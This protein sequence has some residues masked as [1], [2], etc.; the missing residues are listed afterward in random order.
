MI[1]EEL[2]EKIR[3]NQVNLGIIGLG[4]VG[5]PLA[6]HFKE[7]GC[8]VHGFDIDEEKINKLN[9][10]TSY[11]NHIEDKDIDKLIQDGNFSTSDFS[12]ISDMDIL[13]V[14]VPTPIDEQRNPFM[15]HIIDTAEAISKY[16]RKNQLVLIESSTYP[17]TTN[18]LIKPILE[19]SGLICHEDFYLAY[20]PEREDPGNKKFDIGSIPKV[21]GA[22]NPKSLEIALKQTSK[23]LKKEH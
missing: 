21:V 2:I 15:G 13:F 23:V 8:S 6:I 10:G 22:D 3:N 9:N 20:S 7:L 4:Y 1:Y 12:K 16:L 18:E 11:I 19:K 14:C 5:L 17:G